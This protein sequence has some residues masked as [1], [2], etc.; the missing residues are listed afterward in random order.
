MSGLTD[1]LAA[2]EAE[3]ECRYFNRLPEAVGHAQAFTPV[4]FPDTMDAGGTTGRVV[5]TRFHLGGGGA[6]HGGAV[7]LL[8]DSVLGRLANSS[9]AAAMFRT[10]QLDVSYRRITPIGRELAVEAT[11][12]RAEGRKLFVTGSLGDGHEVLAE[13]KGIFVRLLP[14][15]Q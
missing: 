6:A 15:Q 11:V 5:F 2:F 4:F 10:V 14:G 9:E 12:T 13:A 1:E 3:E 8:F 7:A